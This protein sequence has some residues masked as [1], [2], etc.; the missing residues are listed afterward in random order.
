MGFRDLGAPEPQLVA[1]QGLALQEGDG[2]PGVL[3]QGLGG[4][5]AD[6][7]EEAPV[8]AGRRVCMPQ[9]VAELAELV[10]AQ[11]GE[12]PPLRPFELVEQAERHHPAG[13]RER[14]PVDPWEAAP[15]DQVSEFQR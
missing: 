10:G 11:V 15:R 13:R 8:V 9:E 14:G 3:V 7:V 4:V 2:P 6:P 12:G 1:L 5:Q